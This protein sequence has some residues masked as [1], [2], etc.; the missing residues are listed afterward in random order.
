[1][2]EQVQ[3]QIL[4]EKDSQRGSKS[5]KMSANGPAA[6]NVPQAHLPF[7]CWTIFFLYLCPV[8]RKQFTIPSKDFGNSPLYLQVH[9]VFVLPTTSFSTLLIFVVSQ[10][11]AC[12]YLTSW[13]LSLFLPLYFRS[14]H[15]YSFSSF[16]PDCL[17][18]L[19]F[20]FFITSAL[21]PPSVGKGTL[22]VLQL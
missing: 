19:F 11:L 7:M 9:S 16:L 3:E 1:L 12:Y 22:V 20:L 6:Q 8:Q 15:R 4:K 18:H 2:E 5:K 14:S 13:P 17:A 21:R 10:L